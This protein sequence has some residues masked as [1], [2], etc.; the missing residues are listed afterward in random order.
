MKQINAPKIDS[1]CNTIKE[2]M[3]QLNELKQQQQQQQ[4]VVEEVTSR[5]VV[6]ENPI[7]VSKIENDCATIARQNKELLLKDQEIEQLKQ[8]I[9]SLMSSKIE[10]DCATIASQNKIIEEQANEIKALKEQL[11]NVTTTNDK[12][13]TD[14]ATIKELMKE[15][16]I[17][18]IESDCNTIRELMKERNVP[19]IEADCATIA[20]QNQRIAELEEQLKSREVSIASPA[21]NKIAEDCATINELMKQINAPK[22]ESDCNTIRELM[23]ERN[24]PKIEADCATIASQNQR[25]AEL[26]EQLKSREV[27]VASSASNKIADDCA[28]ILSQNQTIKE[29]EETLKTNLNENEILRDSNHAL[30][31]NV[32]ELET[33]LK[34]LR[35]TYLAERTKY[36]NLK[37]T[38]TQLKI[39]NARLSSDLE[40]LK[41][42]TA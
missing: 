19:K 8:Q 3:K 31:N 26:E 2:L 28:T 29:L 24:V 1:D 21:N 11:A 17:P 33:V 34:Q 35:T 36:G 39:E 32:Q 42:T 38:I 30:T 37:D 9:Q 6:I 40:T 13:A 20:S 10:N 22:I 5:E 23:K 4:P 27:A 14:C 18:K 7:E 41:N 16:N 25:I 15:R 12:I